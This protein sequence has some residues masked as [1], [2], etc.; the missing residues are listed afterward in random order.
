MLL[1]YPKFQRERFREE[2]LGWVMKKYKPWKKKIRDF[3]SEIPRSVMMLR[4]VFRKEL[5]RFADLSNSVWVYSM[6]KGYLERSESMRRLQQWTEEKGIPFVF[7]H[8]SGHAKL[9]DLKRLA[10]TLSPRVL[11]PIHS[12]HGE[13]FSDHFE[14]VHSLDDGKIFKV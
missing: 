14:N 3:S 2:G 10:K 13:L 4:V 9:S 6:W 7:L 1:W 11:I 8:T 12:Y 5:E